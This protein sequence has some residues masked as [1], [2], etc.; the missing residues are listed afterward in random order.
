MDNLYEIL[1]EKC[2]QPLPDPVNVVLNEHDDIED[3]F[4]GSGNPTKGPG[5]EGNKLKSS[6]RPPA[7]SAYEI[8]YEYFITGDT[9]VIVETAGDAMPVHR[10]MSNVLRKIKQAFPDLAKHKVIYRDHSGVY[11]GV[12]MSEQGEFDTFYL[13]NT[14]YFDRALRQADFHAAQEF[15]HVHPMTFEEIDAAV[16]ISKALTEWFRI[17]SQYAA[18]GMASQPVNYLPAIVTELIVHARSVLKRTY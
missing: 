3:I 16:N 11:C 1:C 7:D 15:K 17:Q 8:C 2:L 13:I 12:K 10:D 5:A 4:L 9:V 14:P 18:A 6:F